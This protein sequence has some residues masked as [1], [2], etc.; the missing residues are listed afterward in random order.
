MNTHAL[1]LDVQN[2]KCQQRGMGHI[3]LLT[4]SVL[5]IQTKPEA[6]IHSSAIL[7]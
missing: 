6:C 2:R 5:D 7:T 3:T 1:G 4:L